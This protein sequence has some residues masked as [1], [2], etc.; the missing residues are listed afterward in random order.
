MEQEAVT[1]R[2]VLLIPTVALNLV[3]VRS[4]RVV[5]TVTRLGVMVVVRLIVVEGSVIVTVGPV[6]VE[7]SVTTT[8][9]LTIGV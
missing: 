3:T 5:V 8:V 4:V 7:V 1:M 2:V 9:E 6:E